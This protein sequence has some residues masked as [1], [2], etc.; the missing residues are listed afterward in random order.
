MKRNETEQGWRLVPDA[1][2][3]S[4]TEQSA[5]PPGGARPGRTRVGTA[6]RARSKRQRP[7]AG[8]SARGLREERDGCDGRA[9]RGA[10]GEAACGVSGRAVGASG[11]W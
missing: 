10:D 6:Q 1:R 4:V 9:G 7:D 8:V 3:D 5:E 11:P 2:W